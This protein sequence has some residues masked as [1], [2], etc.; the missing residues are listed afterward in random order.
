[1]YKH[2]L[3][4]ILCL[5]VLTTEAKRKSVY[6]GFLSG[7]TNIRKTHDVTTHSQY[8]NDGDNLAFSFTSEIN[9]DKKNKK[10]FLSIPIRLH[11]I[12]FNVT[13][14]YVY[15]LYSSYKYN[16]SYTVTSA[17]LGAGLALNVVPVGNE[18]IAM[19]TSL[20]VL[21]VLEAGDF[22]GGLRANGV[23]ELY[24]GMRLMNRLMLGVRYVYYFR[25]YTVNDFTMPDRNAY[26]VSN[27]LFDM[28]FNLKGK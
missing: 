25:D 13:E 24:G 15:P 26:G 8:K 11:T 19:I 18:K 14:K 20:S 27:I 5:C 2:L 17:A 4:S 12:R 22:M 7:E 10:V 21:P 28:R 3:T 1:M 6:V 16:K 9:F 23:G